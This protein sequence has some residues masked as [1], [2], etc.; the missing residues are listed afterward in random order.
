VI[1]DL[2]DTSFAARNTWRVPPPYIMI[3]AKQILHK[4]QARFSMAAPKNASTLQE[5][6]VTETFGDGLPAIDR[7]KER[8]L[9]RKLDRYIVP[10]V[11]LLYL[12][13]FLDRYT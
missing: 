6:K 8:Q 11:M 9:V 5:H 10:V 2:Y 4:L 12:F 1:P 3:Y 7:K 13:S